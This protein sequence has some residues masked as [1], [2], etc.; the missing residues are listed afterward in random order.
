[1]GSMIIK[2]EPCNGSGHIEVN[3]E[4]PKSESEEPTKTSSKEKSN[5]KEKKDGS[6]G[7]K[8]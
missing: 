6:Q 5:A 3:P 7:K 2:C 4:V 8:G 1:M